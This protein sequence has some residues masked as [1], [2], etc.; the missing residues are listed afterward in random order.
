M[1]EF[2]MTQ[3]SDER[4]LLK[5]RNWYIEPVGYCC[6][7]PHLTPC[8]A[9][10]CRARICLLP[11]GKVEFS[12]AGNQPKPC[13]L[14]VPPWHRQPAKINAVPRGSTENRSPRAV[15]KHEAVLR[16]EKSWL[17]PQQAWAL[18]WA[19]TGVVWRSLQW[20]GFFPV[21]IWITQMLPA[22]LD[23]AF[24]SGTMWKGNQKANQNNLCETHPMKKLLAISTLFY[25]KVISPPALRINE[26][27]SLHPKG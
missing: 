1:L 21:L 20:W 5:Y 15:W 9:G 7:S 2:V 6:V 11:A 17:A 18:N 19:Y 22:C 27:F 14:P 26:C 23:Y 10:I 16:Y 3:M 8:K 24:L 4:P 13:A 12:P 25:K